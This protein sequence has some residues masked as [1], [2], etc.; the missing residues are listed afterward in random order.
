MLVEYL[1][2]AERQ[3]KEEKRKRKRERGYVPDLKASP[4]DDITEFARAEDTV[5]ISIGPVC[6]CERGRKE[7]TRKEGRRE[8][9]NDS[10]S[11]VD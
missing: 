6:C 8:D 9:G 4:V 2:Q 3:R 1:R 10:M 7:E 11:V 5:V